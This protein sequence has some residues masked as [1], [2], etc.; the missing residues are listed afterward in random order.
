MKEN[1]SVLAGDPN[2]Q[3][4]GFN[5]PVEEAPTDRNAGSLS[6]IENKRNARD[7]DERRVHLLK[8]I[9]L[10]QLTRVTSRLGGRSKFQTIACPRP[11][12]E[13]F[14]WQLFPLNTGILRYTYTIYI[15]K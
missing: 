4:E 13:T 15:L 6:F 9:I 14:P 1:G 2:Q 12:H 10:S 3:K 5:R 11:N 8:K 7:R